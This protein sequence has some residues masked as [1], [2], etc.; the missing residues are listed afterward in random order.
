V[1]AVKGE[2]PAGR[3]QSLLLKMEERKTRINK[4]Q[5]G[6]KIEAD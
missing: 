1:I 5:G 3:S 6:K 2:C 4:N